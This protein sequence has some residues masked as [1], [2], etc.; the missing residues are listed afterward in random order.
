V[1][2]DDLEALDRRMTALQFVAATKGLSPEIRLMLAHRI[3]ETA[4]AQRR[5]QA[6]LD[7][8]G[9]RHVVLLRRG[10]RKR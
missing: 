7:R 6:H 8:L 9:K 5:V 4:Q 1:S 10:R 3:A 2:I